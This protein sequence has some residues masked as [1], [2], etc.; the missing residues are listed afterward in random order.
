MKTT[1]ACGRILRRCICL[2]CLFLIVCCHAEDS[3]NRSAPLR[4]RVP[5]TLQGVHPVVEVR[6]KDNALRF[7]VDT[8]ADQNVISAK[9]AAKLGLVPSSQT[10]PGRGAAG[11]F[12]AVPWVHL[13]AL[14]IGNER[15]RD[16]TAFIVAL[17][18]EADAD[19]ILGVPLLKQFVV[20]LDYA[21]GELQLATPKQ[22]H[23]PAGLEALPLRFEGGKILVQADAAGVDGWYSLDT[24][25]GD[26]VTMF[27]P[28]VERMHLR[29]SLGP[30]LRMV[31]GISP[32]GY[33]RG[34][35]VRV[36]EVR[37]GPH[38]FERVVVELSL[39]EQGYFA[40][41]LAD[42]QGNL[43]GELWRRFSLTID[44]PS[45]HLYLR[46]NALYAQP[47][48][49]TRSGLV[50]QRQMDRFKVV[51][52]VASTPAAEVGLAVG[53]WIIAING[54]E[55]LKWTQ[56]SFRDLLSAAPGTSVALAVVGKDGRRRDVSLVLKDLL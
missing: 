10:L 32:G 7:I 44:L 19:G 17:P 22:F 40:H 20:T 27:T 21:A 6:I 37:I 8:G 53:D 18:E 11:A 16:Q 55:A 42:T 43:G 23:P 4:G 2:F 24:G 5:M 50:A 25:A 9:A 39:A 52:V 54:R 29:D 31:T 33:T 38:R 28:T 48:T 13:D 51:D 49:A 14:A 15:L 35:L 46:P 30:G 34:E 56:S 26:A 12:G 45:G 41:P 47:F 36:P 1:L 3:A